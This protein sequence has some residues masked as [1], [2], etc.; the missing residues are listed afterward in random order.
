MFSTKEEESD[1]GA[2]KYD[3]KMQL[4]EENNNKISF[5]DILDL[6]SAVRSIDTKKF[7]KNTTRALKSLRDIATPGFIVRLQNKKIH[8]KHVE[9]LDR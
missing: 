2:N 9:D 8:A 5:D 6:G 4:I 3:E 1:F 7:V